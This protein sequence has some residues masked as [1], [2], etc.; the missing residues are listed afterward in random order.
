MTPSFKK[1][2]SHFSNI[3]WGN[4]WRWIMSTMLFILV[5]GMPI[6]VSTTIDEGALASTFQ[7]AVI[8]L[9]AVLAAIIVWS[10]DIPWIG[11]T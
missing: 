3:P 8:I 9:S 4:L 2:S 1:M 6:A 10:N 11:D 5:I 7:T